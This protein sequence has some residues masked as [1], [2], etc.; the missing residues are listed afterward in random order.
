[1]LGRCLN[2]KDAAYQRY[3]KRGIGVCERWMTFEFFMAD[4]GLRPSK[5]HS[6]DRID[7]NRGYEK[8]NCRWATDKQQARNARSNRTVVH[9]GLRMTVAGWAE[10]RSINYR[11]LLYRLNADWPLDEALGFAARESARRYRCKSKR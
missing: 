1:M 4:M 6:I 9:R 11:T 2:V 7:N 3:G 8:A 5:L 10:S